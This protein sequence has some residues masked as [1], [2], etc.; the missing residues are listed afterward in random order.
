MP[1]AE[2]NDVANV[3]FGPGTATPGDLKFTVSCRLVPEGQ[4]DLTSPA[5]DS[6]VAHVTYVGPATSAGGLSIGAGDYTVD[7]TLADVWEFD[8]L[9]GFLFTAMRAE[10]VV[11]EN[12][13]T[14]YRR[15]YLWDFII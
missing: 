7:L 10:L 5:L 9:P 4:I 3:Y 8:S 12:G 1:R 14:P 15:A 13:T 2:F 6:P 11:P